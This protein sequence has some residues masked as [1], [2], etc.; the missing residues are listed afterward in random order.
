MCLVAPISHL[1]VLHHPANPRR[2]NRKIALKLKQQQRKVANKKE[3]ATP[4]DSQLLKQISARALKSSSCSSRLSKAGHSRAHRDWVLR[5][6]ALHQPCSS[7][8][9]LHRPLYWSCAASI[10]LYQLSCIFHSYLPSSNKQK[11]VPWWHC[12]ITYRTVVISKGKKI[13]LRA[14]FLC[15]LKPVEFPPGQTPFLCGFSSWRALLELGPPAAACG[16]SFLTAQFFPLFPWTKSQNYAFFLVADIMLLP[17][18]NNKSR[19][20]T[21]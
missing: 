18:K 7:P 15:K 19:L 4:W 8:A 12:T 11:A 21:Q 14:F 10:S 16:G 20:A 3:L 5:C 1:S 9:A 17:P 2:F 6:A 13:F